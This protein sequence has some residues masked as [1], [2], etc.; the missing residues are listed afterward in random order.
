MRCRNC[1]TV[2]MET[3]L[4]C[5]TCH[6]SVASATAAAPQPI[7]K[8]PNG[9]LMLLPIFGGALGGLAYAAL[10][11]DEYSA[12]GSPR[13][14]DSSISFRSLAWGFGIILVLIGCMVLGLAFFQA[15]DTWNVAQRQAKLLT[16]AELRK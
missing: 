9:L 10:T 7:G 12:A 13:G 2:M 5:P 6:A 4:Q 11:H 15:F 16:A 14:G 1:H 8:K 3:D